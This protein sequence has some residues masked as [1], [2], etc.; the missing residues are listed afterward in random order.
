VDVEQRLRLLY[1]NFNAR[2]IDSVLAATTQDVDWPNAWE[3]GRLRGQDAVREY[4]L[5]QWGAIDP[6][7]EPVSIETL[8]DGRVAV[9][10]RQVIRTL[11]GDLLA[12]QRVLHIYELADGLVATMSVDDPER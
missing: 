1:E 4:W 7:V 8:S 2:D 6:H 12:D 3:G 5:R 9:E 10:V 11:A